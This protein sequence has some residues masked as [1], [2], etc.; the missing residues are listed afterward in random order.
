MLL[1]SFDEDLALSQVHRPRDFGD[2][3]R[4]TIEEDRHLGGI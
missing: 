2:I 3:V 1:R 4:A